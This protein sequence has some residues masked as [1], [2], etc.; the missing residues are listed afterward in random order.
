MDRSLTFGPPGAREAIDAAIAKIGCVPRVLPGGRLQVDCP[1]HKARVDLLD[2]A[3]WNDATY[4]DR[5][6]KLA[7]RIASGVP[8]DAAGRVDVAKLA[9]A[10]HHAVTHRVRYLDEGPE[11]MATAWDTWSTGIGDCDDSARLLLALARS[12]RIKAAL[13]AFFNRRDAGGD[14][15]PE[16]ATVML[17]DGTAW[18]WAEPSIRGARF[19][20]EPR[21]AARRLGANRAELLGLGAG[22]QAMGPHATTLRA[23]GVGGLDTRA[24]DALIRKLW[25]TELLPMTDFARQVA[26]SVAR[27]E[28][29]YGAWPAG[30]AM[31]G[32]HNWGAVQCGELPVV[33]PIL[34]YSFCRQAGCA[35][36][37]DSHPDNRRYPACFRTY[38]SHEEGAADLLRHLFKLRAKT[39]AVVTAGGPTRAVSAAM[40]AEHYFGGFCPAAIKAGATPTTDDPRCAA[41]AIDTH[42][43][44][45]R[46]MSAAIAPQLGERD[47]LA[48]ADARR[49]LLVGG[50]VV[51]GVAGGLYAAHRARWI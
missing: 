14:I 1:S 30:S 15:Q 23:L 42:A 5:I 28:S 10:L 7:V 35:A 8:S 46:A 24:A 21:A 16:H 18:R 51:A 37:T 11:T 45:L 39:R 12:V 32:S 27:Y 36:H 49:S 3:A 9:A 13:V 40:H 43:A 33:V 29:G 26:L 19:G 48:A 38:A 47:E 41:E 31:E 17:H 50:L 6:R 34:G 2:A 25:P 44:K 20:E 4:D 22:A